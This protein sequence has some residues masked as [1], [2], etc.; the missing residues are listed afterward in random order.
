VGCGVCDMP[1][2][3]RGAAAGLCA[4]VRACVLVPPNLYI[5]TYRNA[6]GLAEYVRVAPGHVYFEDI[7]MRGTE[8]PQTTSAIWVGGGGA[9]RLID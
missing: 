2:L 7:C 4:R 1:E 6:C 3:W 8:C 9:W 5:H